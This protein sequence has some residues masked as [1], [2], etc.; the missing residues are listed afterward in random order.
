MQC[1]GF[2]GVDPEQPPDTVP[3]KLWNLMDGKIDWQALELLAAVYGVED[4]E[5]LIAQLV[6]IREH[7]QQV[8][9][10]GH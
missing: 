4:M 1:Q 5:I 7:K 2:P 3:I 6:A 9:T 10:V 8:Q